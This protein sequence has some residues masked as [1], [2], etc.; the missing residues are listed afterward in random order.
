MPSPVESFQLTK[1]LNILGNVNQIQHNRYFARPPKVQH[2]PIN[3]RHT[4]IYNE[5]AFNK[6]DMKLSESCSYFCSRHPQIIKLPEPS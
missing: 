3:W 2:E 5:V 6:I 4:N 1:I